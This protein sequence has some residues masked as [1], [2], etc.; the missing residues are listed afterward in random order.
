M[1]REV[2]VTGLGAVSPLGVGARTLHER[3]IAGT[4]VRDEREPPNFHHVIGGE[5]R[6]AI[7]VVETTHA[8]DRRRIGRMQMN[9][10]AGAAP[11]FVHRPVQECFL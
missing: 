7:G 6:N 3:W 9:N 5:R 8:R 2:A 11:H 1:K 4:E 10:G